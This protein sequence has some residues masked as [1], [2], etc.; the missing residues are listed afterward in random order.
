VWGQ[1]ITIKL[2]HGFLQLVHTHCGFTARAIIHWTLE[3][4][5]YSMWIWRVNPLVHHP[6]LSRWFWRIP[7]FL[8]PPVGTYKTNLYHLLGRATPI[9]G[10]WWHMFILGDLSKNRS[11]IWFRW[12]IQ[13]EDYRLPLNVASNRRLPRTQFPIGHPNPNTMLLQIDYP[14]SLM[15]NSSINQN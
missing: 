10:S 14:S 1:E 12:H 15:C 11:L 3:T 13:P 5:S 8:A 4:P 7:A 9:L 2:F 6:S